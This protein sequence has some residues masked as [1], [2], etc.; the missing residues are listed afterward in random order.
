MRSKIFIALV[1]TAIGMSSCD[2][3]KNASSTSKSYNLQ[4]KWIVDSIAAPGPGDTTGWP[5]FSLC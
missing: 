2:G 5:G 3:F 4:G 1:A